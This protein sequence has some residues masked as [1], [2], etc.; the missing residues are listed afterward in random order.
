MAKA[1]LHHLGVFPYCAE[2]GTPAAT[3][4]GQVRRDGSRPGGP[5]RSWLPSAP[6]SADILDGYVGTD[7]EVLVDAPHPEWP[8]L[9][10]GRTWFQAP[11]ID[12]VTYVSGPGVAP[13][14]MVTASIEEAKDYD[15]VG[16]T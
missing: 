5:R 6:I 4:P 12:G 15:L 3:M 13:G 9:H 7:Q 10:L 8:G 1:R 2:E 14:A 11:E 16:L